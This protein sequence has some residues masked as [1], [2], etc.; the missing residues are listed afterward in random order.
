MSLS[1]TL[2]LALVSFMLVGCME[3]QQGP[4][5]VFLT[6]K[7]GLNDGFRKNETLKVPNPHYER[8][9]RLSN[10]RH[11]VI[12]GAGLS[13]LYRPSPRDIEVTIDRGSAA[14]NSTS[15][16][17]TR[18]AAVLAGCSKDRVSDRTTCRMNLLPQGSGNDGGLFQTVSASG[19]ILTACI[20]GHDFPGRTGSIRVDSNTAIATDT[21]GCVSG[22]TA[23]RLE[24]QLRQGSTLITRHVK[25]PYD[26]TRD[27][28]MLIEGSFALA[29]E[30]YRWTATADLAALFSEQ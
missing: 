30:L 7:E 20:V 6:A 17:A 8:M 24:N 9:S 4:P 3:N 19:S 23:R 25:W 26:Y 21:K 28:E 10:S 2:S 12:E 29:Q 11:G 16:H 1:R 18:H 14:T 15:R 13:Y 5:P 22:S 27:R